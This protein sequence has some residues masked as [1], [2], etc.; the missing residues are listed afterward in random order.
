MNAPAMDAK[1]FSITPPLWGNISTPTSTGVLLKWN[2]KLNWLSK[3][4]KWLWRWKS[5]YTRGNKPKF[6]NPQILKNLSWRENS[7][8]FR[9]LSNKN[10]LNN[11]VS[12]PR[13]SWGP[14]PLQLRSKD[15][16]LASSSIPKMFKIFSLNRICP[17][18]SQVWLR[19]TI[20]SNLPNP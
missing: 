4:P 11:S 7:A 5:S 3:E 20:L 19:W 6:P 16:C 9:T 17:L 10:F 13:S 18:I 2:S 1:N 14:S 15:L 12:S 8:K